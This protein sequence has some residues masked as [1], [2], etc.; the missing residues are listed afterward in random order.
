MAASL[1]RQNSS[2]LQSSRSGRD[3]KPA[4]LT[5]PGRP[6]RS[7]LA[8]LSDPSFIPSPRYFVPKSELRWFSETE[9]A[10]AFKDITDECTDN[11]FSDDAKV[12]RQDTRQASWQGFAVEGLWMRAR[13]CPPIISRASAQA[14][15]GTCS[16]L[17]CSIQA[18]A[19]VQRSA[20]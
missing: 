3:H 15:V 4:N 9:W 2:S 18:D 1:R 17:N 7:I 20:P 12:S 11:D 16:C 19:R 13:R 6:D 14:K 10:I 8:Q 5:R